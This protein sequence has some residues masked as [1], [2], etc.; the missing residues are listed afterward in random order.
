MALTK[1]EEYE[2]GGDKVGIER[3]EAPFDGGQD[4]EGAVASYTDGMTF[5][6]ICATCE[7]Q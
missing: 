4:P 2:V 7:K 5:S 3:P 1:Y 6:K